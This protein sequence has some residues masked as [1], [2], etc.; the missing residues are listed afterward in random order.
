MIQWH[1]GMNGIRTWEMMI[2]IHN[3]EESPPMLVNKSIPYRR[4]QS[5]ASGGG[6]D[7]R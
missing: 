2:E 5:A 1:Y 3:E 6:P 4:R 7:G